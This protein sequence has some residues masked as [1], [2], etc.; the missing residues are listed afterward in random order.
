MLLYIVKIKHKTFTMVSL[1]NT[2]QKKYQYN[3]HKIG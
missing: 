2:N 3:M 1:F